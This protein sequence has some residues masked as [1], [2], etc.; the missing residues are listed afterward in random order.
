MSTTTTT[1]PIVAVG[2]ECG[3]EETHPLV[4]QVMTFYEQAHPLVEQAKAIVVTD[5]AQVTLMR[6][7]RKI[8]LEMRAIRV[9]CDKARKASKEEALRT[10]QAI[11][12]LFGSITKGLDA[13]E[14][15]LEEQEKFA[16]RL[17]A[18]RKAQLRQKRMEEIAPYAANLAGIIPEEMGGQEWDDF[19]QLAK[20]AHERR[21]EEAR[22]AE[23]ERKAREEE[24]AKER[25]RLRAEK[26]KA[27]AEAAQA[28]REAEEARR[29]AREAEEAA[30]AERRK[31]DQERRQR[32][33][34]EARQKA[35]EAKKAADAERARRAAE[36]APDADK[37][38][39]FSTALL[40]VAM[41]AMATVDGRV[42]AEEVRKE[43]FK[44]A[45]WVVAA[46][47]S[48]GGA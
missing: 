22:K 45:E 39:A 47:D 41:P 43:V 28:R 16:E 38:R 25:E 18:Q 24:A 8:R 44:L 37:I 21:Q 7:A 2:R 48:L 35:E 20:D 30:E 4:A 15:R 33:A 46:A 11:D 40:D 12:K 19:L 27:D 42:V 13:E 14:A 26:A 10:S 6:Q 29:K 32:E 3:L 5:A 1:N 23:E 34:A 9:A 17:E 36:A 31:A